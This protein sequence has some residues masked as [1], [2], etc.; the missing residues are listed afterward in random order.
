MVIWNRRKRRQY[1][2]DQALLYQEAV[3]KAI[4]A[5]SSGKELNE[6]QR[7]ILGRERVRFEEQEAAERRKKERWWI[8]KWLLSG[9]KLG[10]EEDVETPAAKPKTIGGEEDTSEGSGENYDGTLSVSTT[11]PEETTAHYSIVPAVQDEIPQPH[12]PSPDTPAYAEKEFK[13]PTIHDSSNNNSSPT[14]EKVQP[15]R[16]WWG[17]KG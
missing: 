13:T 11:K 1:I 9:L 15:K 4:E 16:S 2:K 7:L 10:E 8:T 3:S 6:E 14:N 12:P 17:G 5:E